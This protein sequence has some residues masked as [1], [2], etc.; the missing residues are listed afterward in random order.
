MKSN[1]AITHIGKKLLNKSPTIKLKSAPSL[2]KYIG[3]ISNG[4]YILLIGA[5]GTSKTRICLRLFVLDV[6]DFVK[7]NIHNNIDVE[8]AYFSLELSA[9][10]IYLNIICALLHEKTGNDYCIDYFENKLED[11]KLTEH[12]YEEIRIIQDELNFLDTKLTVYDNYFQPKTIYNVIHKEILLKN[13]IFV[14]NIYTKHNE[15]KQV[16]IIIDTINALRAEL[17]KSEYDCIKNFSE[18][19]CKQRLKMQFDCTII[20]V[21]QTD[22]SSTTVLFNNKGEKVE[23]KFTPKLENLAKVKTTP[24]DASL[25]LS[26]FSP[27]RYDIQHYEGYNI[28]DFGNDFRYLKILKNTNGDENIGKAVKINNPHLFI[29]ELP[30]A[31][32]LNQQKTKRLLR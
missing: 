13:G 4:E 19:I 21:Q 8:I 12:I 14:N 22:K 10:R 18:E 1:V 2:S 3:G 20:C 31:K 16:I 30:L 7:N 9:V 26:I 23:D 15:N 28:N 17:G 29:K 27:F 5:T 6:V 32:E 24:D 11:N 25:V